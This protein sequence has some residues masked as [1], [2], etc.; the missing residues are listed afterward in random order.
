LIEFADRTGCVATTRGWSDYRLKPDGAGN[1][2]LHDEGIKASKISV[3]TEVAVAN[4]GWATCF[5]PS[6]VRTSLFDHAIIDK[7]QM[8]HSDEVILSAML[9]SPRYVV[10]MPK[11]FYADL[12]APVRLWQSPIATRAKLAQLRL[13]PNLSVRMLP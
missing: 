6:S 12:S 4:S 10:P 13:S 11:R 5:R 2:I 3:P 8:R 9:D 7:A 1:L